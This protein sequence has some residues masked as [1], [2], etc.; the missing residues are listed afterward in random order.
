MI[1]CPS[2]AAQIAPQLICPQCGAPQPLD[3]DCFAALGIQRNLT[4]DPDYLETAYHDLSRKVHP[5]RFATKSAR[6]RDSSLRA[7]SLLTRAYR[8]LRDPVGRGLYWLELN[9]D[10]LSDNNNLVPHDLAELVFDVQDQLEELRAHP[11]FESRHGVD[12]RRLTLQSVLN[13]ATTR[14]AANFGKWDSLETDRKSLMD[15]LKSILSRIAYLRTLIRDVDRA[16]E[17]TQTGARA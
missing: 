7:T 2:C 6:L 16:L 1:K 12:S 13:D 3:L 11:S 4:I 8:T 10:K 9:G 17:E 14:L 5:D 15:E